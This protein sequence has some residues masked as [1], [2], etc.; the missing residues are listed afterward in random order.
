LW[1]GELIKLDKD[2]YQQ[3]AKTVAKALIGKRL[4]TNIGSKKI[5][6]IVETEAYLGPHDL[7]C[8]SA[9]GLTTRTKVMFGPAAKTYVYLIYGIHTMFNI[10]T[11]NSDG[12]AVLIRAVEPVSLIKANTNGPGKLTKALGIGL[13]HND[14]S[15]LNNTIYLEDAKPVNKIITTSR[16]GIDYAKEW[17]DAP[18]R[19]YDFDSK[20]VSKR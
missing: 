16:I 9:K 15:L 6:R 7:A 19:F 17:K 12:Q 2:F 8:H 18:L 3:D 13:E 1:F 4:I 11:G 10:V 5:S 20:F 14:I